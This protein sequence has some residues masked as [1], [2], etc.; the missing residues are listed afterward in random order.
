[1]QPRPPL[2]VDLFNDKLSIEVPLLRTN[3]VI[4]IL[5]ESR[6]LPVD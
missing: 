5:A 4:R 6:P 2:L 1:M 3:K